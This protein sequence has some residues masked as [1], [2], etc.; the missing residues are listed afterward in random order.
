MTRKDEALQPGLVCLDVDGTL[1]ARD[2]TTLPEAGH[3]VAMCEQVGY[4]VALCSARSAIGL[5]DIAD[6]L[7]AVDWI[8][9]LG[10]ARIL[11]RAGSDWRSGSKEVY[12]V[13]Y[14]DADLCADLVEMLKPHDL[15][16]WAFTDSEWLVDRPSARTERETFITKERYR[17]AADRQFPRNRVLKFVLPDVPVEMFE[18]VAE[19]IARLGLAA[20]YSTGSQVEIGSAAV[21]DK[22]LGVVRAL[23]GL[24]GRPCIAIGD[25]RNDLG[26]LRAADHSLTFDDASPE[27]RQ[28]ADEILPADR[29]IALLLAADILRDLL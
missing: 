22:G 4:V 5:S 15:D 24:E 14:L 2:G 27:M 28:A 11:R 8:A 29:R 25:G 3:L 9:S 26:M 18:A 16:I 19:G 7:G 21:T 17:V 23:A 6:E 12:R 10:G 20:S 1:V 13:P